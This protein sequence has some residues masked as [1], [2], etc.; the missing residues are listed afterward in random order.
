MISKKMLIGISLL[1]S[2]IF[3][4]SLF[5]RSLN[6]FSEILLISIPLLVISIITYFL[7]DSIYSKLS[8]FIKI[9]VPLTMFLVFISPEYGSGLVPIDKERVS[10]TMIFLFLI[11]SILTILFSYL[12]LKSEQRK[13]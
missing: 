10:L 9:W 13:R 8:R 4:L 1:L 2:A 6:Y 5:V 12:S 3:T 11:I 7:Q